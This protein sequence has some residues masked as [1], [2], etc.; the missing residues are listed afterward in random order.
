MWLTIVLPSGAATFT[1]ATTGAEVLLE[2][3][4][5]SSLNQDV[6]LEI[7]IANGFLK[8]SGGTF[9]WN[10]Q[11]LAVPSSLRRPAAYRCMRP[12]YHAGKTWRGSET[13]QCVRLRYKQ[14]SHPTYTSIIIAGPGNSDTVT[15][16]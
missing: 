3:N 1:S 12:I 4:N 5:S 11:A 7:E 14:S 2:I 9:D 13:V 8:F 6:Q 16:T 15:V 10:A